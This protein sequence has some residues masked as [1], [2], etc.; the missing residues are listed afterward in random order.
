MQGNRNKGFHSPLPTNEDPTKGWNWGAFFL[1]WIWGLGNRTWIALL[2]LI[3]FVNF[4]MMVVLGLK[5]NQWAWEKGQWR[6][7]THFRKVQRNWAIAGTLLFAVGFAGAGYAFYELRTSPVTR[8]SYERLINHPEGVLRLGAP[9]QMGLVVW[10]EINVHGDG[11]ANANITYSVSGQANEGRLFAQANRVDNQW[12]FNQMELVIDGMDPLNLLLES[13]PPS[14]Q[15]STPE[16]TAPSHDDGHQRYVDI[17]PSS[18]DQ[19]INRGVRVLLGSGEI[20]AGTLKSVD[21]SVITIE[22]SSVTGP[23]DEEIYDTYI[24]QMQLWLGK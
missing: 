10:G 15:A 7:E 24:K 1:T 19:H 14:P 3:P 16:T 21:G 2:A 12:R 8:L 18:A 13:A 17:D 5:G 6:D 22:T 4:I 20:I 11:S 9:V 23:V